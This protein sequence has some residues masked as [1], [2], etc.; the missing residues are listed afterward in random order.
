MYDKFVTT[1]IYFTAIT[2]KYSNIII[3]KTYKTAA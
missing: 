3:Y 2:S 1:V